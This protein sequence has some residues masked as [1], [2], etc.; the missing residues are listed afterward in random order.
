MKITQ[1][2]S[3]VINNPKLQQVKSYVI[4]WEFD[5]MT[6]HIIYRMLILIMCNEDLSRREEGITKTRS[7]KKNYAK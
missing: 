2:R 4:I 1:I 5:F 6:S 7:S 3:N